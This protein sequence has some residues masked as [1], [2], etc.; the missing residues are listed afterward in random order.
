MS[1]SSPRPLVLMVS[2]REEKRVQLWR[3][4]PVPPSTFDLRGSEKRGAWG[5][6][7]GSGGDVGGC[8]LPWC[9]C[10]IS[11][12]GV[13]LQ[14]AGEL[15]RPHT[16][17]SSPGVHGISD[18]YR[19]PC[20]AFGSRHCSIGSGVSALTQRAY[21]GQTACLQM[22]PCRLRPGF[23]SQRAPSLIGEV[24]CLLIAVAYLNVSY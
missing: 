24:C 17:Q 15:H 18:F 8:W 5:L 19:S 13:I 2:A 22:L 23:A 10:L 7:S 20:P 1:L 12:L 21:R 3:A 16:A 4:V 11:G 14:Q 9:C 6:L